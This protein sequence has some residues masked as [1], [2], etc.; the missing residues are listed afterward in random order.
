MGGL[1]ALREIV[2]SALHSGPNTRSRLNERT[3]LLN[4]YE[5]MVACVVALPPEERVA[6][7]EWDKR[8]PTGLGTSDWPGFEKY[9]P[10]KP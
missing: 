10:K 8:R 2:E 5:R 1:E 9:L 7:E 4:W 3:E 6:F